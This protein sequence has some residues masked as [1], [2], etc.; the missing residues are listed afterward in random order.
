MKKV[1]PICKKTVD[2][3]MAQ[4]CD[5]AEDW[6]LATIRR[7]HP[8]WVEKDGSCSKCLAYYRTMNPSDS[9]GGGDVGR[10]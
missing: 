4:A 8:D 6:I 10:S 9:R 3:D 7:S 1:C 2:E 5:K